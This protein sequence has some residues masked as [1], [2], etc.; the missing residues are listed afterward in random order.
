MAEYHY[1]NS[2]FSNFATAIIHLPKNI[3]KNIIIFFK[4]IGMFFISIFNAFKS[5]VMMFIKGDI[6]TK[7]SYLIMGFGN[8]CRGQIIKGLLF[9]GV[10]VAYIY[11]LITFGLK[12][13]VHFNTLGV[14]IKYEVWDQEL[15]IFKYIQGDNSMLILLYS[16]FTIFI[17]LAFLVV[18]VVS[19]KSSYKAQLIK[20]SGKKLP[21]IIDDIKSLLDEKFHITLLSL[22]TI[23]VIAFTILP[24]VFMVL[25][26]FTNFDANHQPPGNLFTWV[27]LNNFKNLFV[28]DKVQS[29]TFWGVL[30][31]TLVWAVI[32]TVT[33]YILGMVLAMAI[34]KKGI[35]LKSMWRTI[36]VITIAVPQF[37]TLLLVSK[38]LETSGPINAI[39]Q[40]LGWIKSAIPFLTNVNYARITV[41]IVNLWIGIPYTMLITTGILMNIPQE[42]Y[43]SARIDGA[44]PYKSFTKI[45]LPYMLFVTTPYLITAFI[46]NIN[47]F[48]VIYL[49][50][51]G[52]PKSLDYYQAGKTDL[53]VT[54]LYGLTVN[55]QDYNLASTIGILIFVISAV[56]ALITFNITASSKKE[57]QFS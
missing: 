34:N 41:L 32:A 4:A 29:N 23:M 16:V 39:L 13:I 42:M 46:G 27:G 36:F 17:S 30:S 3:L 11:Y 18:Y 52:G 55:Q 2:F 33:S 48:N 21:G 56:F 22:P 31:W 19:I 9:F 5:F 15:E 44:G 51:A 47:N 38:M 43:E 10:Q 8:I 1:N 49:L 6:F 20:K 12:Y 26:A 54:W 50:T 37:V 14:A 53:L 45:T 35:R 24:I 40:Q 57:D 7:V 28:V 25:M